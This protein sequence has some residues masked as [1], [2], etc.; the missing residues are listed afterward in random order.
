M[1]AHSPRAAS[2]R[3]F[4]VSA[5]DILWRLLNVVTAG[6]WV[7]VA[8][9]HFVD[10]S[11]QSVVPGIALLV[12]G[13]M[14]IVLEF[15]RPDSILENCYF[16]WNFMGRAR[17]TMAANFLPRLKERFLWPG[18]PPLTFRITNIVVAILMIVSGIVF[19][20]WK[21]FEHI[22]LGVFELLFGAW[23]IVFELAE[24]P[25]LAQYVQF[26]YTWFGRGLLYVFIGCLTLGFKAFGWVFGAII[27]GVGVVYIVLAFTLKRD[28]SYAAS[29]DSGRPAGES[30]Y[31][32]NAVYGRKLD[33][34][35]SMASV[36]Q[37]LAQ[38]QCPPQP[39]Y[40]TSMYV[41]SHYNSSHPDLDQRPEPVQHQRPESA[42]HP[43]MG[44]V[45]RPGSAQQQQ[46]A[47]SPGREHATVPR[48][49]HYPIE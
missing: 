21:Q 23:I 13:L 35:G 36:Q 45:L 44:P 32:P 29:I 38:S 46:S 6:L 16:L 9:F 1:A 27:A 14:S 41:P 39:Q 22:M 30:I 8:A 28:E 10:R 3:P 18:G 26:M 47:R 5:R 17:T 20:T 15:W 7:A 48:P 34:Y 25:R 12:I 43:Q 2:E 19:F 40:T 4:R 49:L 33:M 11:F 37:S 31:D 24:S 42:Q